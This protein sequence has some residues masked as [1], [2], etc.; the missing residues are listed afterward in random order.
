MTTTRPFCCD[1]FFR[2]GATNMDPLTE[3]YTTSFY[4]SYLARW[5][6]M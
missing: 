6:G 4:L 5:P 1:D 3:T 2:F